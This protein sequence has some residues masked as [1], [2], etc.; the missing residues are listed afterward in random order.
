VGCNCACAPCTLVTEGDKKLS[1]V[2]GA[3]LCVKVLSY[4]LPGRTGKTTIIHGHDNRVLDQTSNE[5]LLIHEAS[6]SAV[7]SEGRLT[8]FFGRDK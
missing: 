5:G 6:A 2:E 7:W 8:E 4:V 3:V 1:R